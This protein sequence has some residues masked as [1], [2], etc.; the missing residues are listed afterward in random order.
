MRLFFSFYPIQQS[1]LQ[2]I[3]DEQTA[4]WWCLTRKMLI[5]SER[6]DKTIIKFGMKDSLGLIKVLRVWAKLFWKLMKI[7]AIRDL[8]KRKEILLCFFPRN[9]ENARKPEDLCFV[10]LFRGHEW[11]GNERASEQGVLSYV[12]LIV[13]DNELTFVNWRWRLFWLRMRSLQD[14]EL[15]DHETTQ[16]N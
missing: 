9:A 8:E 14:F 11:D 4:S 12:M 3:R 13:I 6:D 7:S 5:S 15:M 10:C 1:T 2:L 16:I